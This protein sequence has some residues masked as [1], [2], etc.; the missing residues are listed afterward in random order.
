MNYQGEHNKV[1][2]AYSNTMFRSI[3]TKIG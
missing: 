2:L 1:A 3:M